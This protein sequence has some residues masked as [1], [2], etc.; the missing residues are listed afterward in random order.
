[1]EPGT[2]WETAVQELENR[3]RTL[4]M[5][6]MRSLS[7]NSYAMAPVPMT[8]PSDQRSFF[9]KVRTSV[10]EGDLAGLTALLGSAEFSAQSY[11]D[12]K[13]SNN[14]SKQAAS[15]SSDSPLEASKNL[16]TSTGDDINSNNN[17][18]NNNNN[19]DE[20]DLDTSFIDENEPFHEIQRQD[21][22][23]SV[24]NL[25]SVYAPDALIGRFTPP[26]TA[27]AAAADAT[28]TTGM[29]DEVSSSSSSSIPQASS[30]DQ[31]SWYGT[32]V[33]SDPVKLNKKSKSY[34]LVAESLNRTDHQ[35][36]S[37]LMEIVKI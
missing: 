6:S 10:M 17:N 11:V 35:G 1:M 30:T 29:G 14:R 21:S 23:V 7:F 19:L 8:T 16:D 15:S 2:P 4:S 20:N 32:A 34:S 13:T 26:F 25:M 33:R 5:K 9:T 12:S 28:D 27:T 18:N 22:Y 24:S 3:Q 36:V 31:Q 37:I